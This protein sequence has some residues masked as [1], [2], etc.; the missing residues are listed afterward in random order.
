MIPL[1]SALILALCSA[2]VGF[3]WGRRV[4]DPDPS[5]TLYAAGAWAVSGDDGAY[6]LTCR[7]RPIAR[8]VS[9][10]HAVAAADRQV[11]A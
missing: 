6:L 3:A 4:P 10:R 5:P 2:L 8:F 9:Y 7:G 11:T 1:I